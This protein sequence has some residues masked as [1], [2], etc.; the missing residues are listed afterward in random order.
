MINS[1]PTPFN[2]SRIHGEVPPEETKQFLLQQLLQRGASLQPRPEKLRALLEQAIDM[3]APPADVENSGGSLLPETIRG[4]ASTHAKV[5]EEKM[6]AWIAVRLEG[7]L[8]AVVQDIFNRA[9]AM[10]KNSIGR[11]TAT[12][13]SDEPSS[14]ALIAEA[15][16]PS[17]DRQQEVAAKMARLVQLVYTTAASYAVHDPRLVDAIQV[18]SGGWDGG[19]ETFS[20]KYHI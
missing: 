13:M 14:D 15:A 16:A 9:L 12:P 20:A 5:V 6:K 8:N 1:F 2:P 4:L 18:C 19:R 17:S 10:E 7:A 3:F 11:R